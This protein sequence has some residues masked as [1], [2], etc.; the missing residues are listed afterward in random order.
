MFR[1]VLRRLFH[2]L[3]VHAADGVLL[4]TYWLTMLMNK[5][6]LVLLPTR[7]FQNVLV[8]P[9]SIICICLVAPRVLAVAGKIF[10][11][12]PSLAGK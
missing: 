7:L 4:Q 6:Y 1:P 5:A 11:A 12:T 3:S 2:I 10:G 9:V 8:A